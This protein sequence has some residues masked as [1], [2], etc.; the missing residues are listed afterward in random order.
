MSS[1]TER[2]IAIVAEQLR[3]PPE[4]VTLQSHLLDDLGADSLDVVD[5][6]IAIEEEF[7]TDDHPIE[8]TEDVAAK[9]LTVQNIL[10][11]LQENGAA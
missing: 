8:I 2:L 5:L 11:F 1:T 6:S 9:M 3:V 7:A 10:T 4:K